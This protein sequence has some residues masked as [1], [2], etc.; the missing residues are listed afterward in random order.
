MARQAKQVHIY[1]YKELAK[2]KFEYAIFQRSDNAL[3]WQGIS[4]G[5][6][7]G[8]SIEEAARREIFEEAGIHVTGP[9][10]RLDTICSLPAYIFQARDREH[11]PE[12]LYVVPLYFFAVAYEGPIRLSEE[13]S[14]V[15]WLPYEEAEKLVYFHDQKTAL[16]E[17]DQRLK[18]GDI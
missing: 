1:L 16:W 8:E 9:L 5:L 10:S 18:M 15:K 6:E 13:H 11:W 14:D 4:G 7:A 3:W 17:L 12:N 2:G